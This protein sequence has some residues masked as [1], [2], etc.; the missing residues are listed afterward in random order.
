MQKMARSLEGLSWLG[1]Q[2]SREP[3][4]SL[5]LGALVGCLS[6]VRKS[7]KALGLDGD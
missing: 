6:R 4:L 1:A 3:H 7:C 5:L 2:V